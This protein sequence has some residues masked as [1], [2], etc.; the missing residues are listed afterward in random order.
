LAGEILCSLAGDYPGDVLPNLIRA[1][2]GIWGGGH[3]ISFAA[4]IRIVLKAP[5]FVII[6]PVSPGPSE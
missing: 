3:D 4:G 1:K 2:P 5:I 6:A